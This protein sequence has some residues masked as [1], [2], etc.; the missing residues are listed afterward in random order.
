M[1]R[2]GRARGVNSYRFRNCARRDLPLLARWLRAPQVRRWWGDPAEQLA[3]VAADLG[4]AQMRQWI[5][6]LRGDP[7]AYAQAYEVHSWGAPHLAAL[8]QG[9]MAIDCFI[10][11]PA[12]LGQGHG[13]GFLRALARKLLRDGAP[14]VAID[15]D[16]ANEQAR[17]AFARAGFHGDTVVAAPE[18]PAVLMLFGGGAGGRTRT[19]TLLPETDFESVA[20]TIP[21]HP[22]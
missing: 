8:P 22:Q 16:P 3:L 19:D 11:E 2:S 10:G 5:V 17:R 20:S 14:L 6:S 21:P 15:P 7:F 18:G 1:I 4:E 12:L 9:T 13:A